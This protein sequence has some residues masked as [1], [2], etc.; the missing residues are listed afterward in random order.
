MLPRFS[1]ENDGEGTSTYLMRNSFSR[2]YDILGTGAVPA[3]R[4]RPCQAFGA[5]ASTDLA[6]LALENDGAVVLRGVYSSEQISVWRQQFDGGIAALEPDMKWTGNPRVVHLGDNGCHAILHSPHRKDIWPYDRIVTD[7]QMPQNYAPS[8]LRRLLDQASDCSIVRKSLGALP[9]EPLC[10]DFGRWHRDSEPLFRWR[11][12]D[13]AVQ[14]ERNTKQVP[15]YY[16][17][18]FIALDASRTDSGATECI[19]GSHR[20]SVQEAA[21]PSTTVGCIECEPGDVALINGKLIHRGTANLSPMRRRVLYA[22]WT[23]PWFD[24]EIA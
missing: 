4:R 9:L 10:E 15:D 18:S 14:D 19:I 3:H 12:D 23:A 24:E 11:E 6:R 13:P 22:V 21:M 16:F 8:R 20:M 1:S 7:L 17:T 2:I 5:G